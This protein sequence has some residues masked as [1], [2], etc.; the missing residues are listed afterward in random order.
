MRQLA[1]PSDTLYGGRLVR[2][3][4]AEEA[5]LLLFTVWRPHRGLGGSDGRDTCQGTGAYPNLEAPVTGFSTL[6]TPPLVYG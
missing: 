5:D 2:V 4:E 3:E 6:A 1:G